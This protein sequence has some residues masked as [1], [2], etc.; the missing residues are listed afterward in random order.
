MVK[1]T[2]KDI[3]NAISK[4]LQYATENDINPLKFSS[5][6]RC[7]TSKQI[8]Y[9]K[10]FDEVINDLLNKP[11]KEYLIEVVVFK[12]GEQNPFLKNKLILEWEQNK[13][14]P[15][16]NLI[17]RY[18]TGNTNTKTND[19]IHVFLDN[20][21]IYAINIDGTPHDGSKAK[22]GSKEVTFLKNIGFTP[23]PDGI[24]EWF[25]LDPAQEYTAIKRHLLFD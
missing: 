2:K 19:H 5:D 9:E 10:K 1:L 16:T 8:I 25:T 21:Q 12:N 23:P 20:N 18:D 17:Y 15:K 24:L 14:I 7:K 11:V 13:K 4:I 3:A 6:A 22:L